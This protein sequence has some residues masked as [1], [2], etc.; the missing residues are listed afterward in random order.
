MI[1]EALARNPDDLAATGGKA[2]ALAWEGRHAEARALLPEMRP[3]ARLGQTY[4]HGTY[5]RA[6]VSALGGD[7]D[8]A[9][10]WL[11]ETVDT[12]LRVYPA[13]VRDR[14]FDR[15]RQTAQFKRF[16][17]DFKPIWDEYERRLR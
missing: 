2:L 9:T 5:L 1:D 4:H 11:Q 10:H 16:L 7:A 8:D 6:C 15:V 13:F 3:A 12:G 17:T 14:C